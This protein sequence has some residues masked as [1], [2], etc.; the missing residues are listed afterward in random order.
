MP[1]YITRPSVPN[2]E[3]FKKYLRKLYKTRMLTTNGGLVPL[4]EKKIK[5][6]LGIKYMALTCNGTIAIEVALKTL[7]IKKGV[8][9]TPF[10]YISTSNACKWVGLKTTFSDIEKKNYSLDFNKI[11]KEELKKIDCL[12]ATNVFGITNNIKNLCKYA[13]KN[14][15]KII[16]DAAHCFDPLHKK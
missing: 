7:K 16:F 11:K 12:I 8:L 15:K 2:I 4:L 13:K 14:K 9:T 10:S 1:I 3:I 5:K 6:I